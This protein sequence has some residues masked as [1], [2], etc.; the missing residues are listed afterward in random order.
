LSV[1]GDFDEPAIAKLA[2]DLFG[3]WKSGKPFAR[4]RQ[5]YFEVASERKVIEIP[6]KANA[7]YLLGMN[8]NLR[9][10]DPDYPALLM[11]N[12]MLGRGTIKSRLA[13][14]IR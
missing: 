6:D 5:Q 8:L 10:D 7:L 2:N 3:S 13:D 4:V 11:A 12:Y 14:R 9:D 1:V